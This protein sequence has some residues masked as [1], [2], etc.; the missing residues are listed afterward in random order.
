MPECVSR[1][2]DLAWG[3]IFR[4]E[5]KITYDAQIYFKQKLKRERS[6]IPR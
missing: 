2:K 4:I 5:F 6:A 1:Q 3:I